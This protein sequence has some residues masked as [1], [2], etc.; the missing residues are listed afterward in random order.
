MLVATLNQLYYK[1]CLD[2]VMP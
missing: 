1:F 2:A